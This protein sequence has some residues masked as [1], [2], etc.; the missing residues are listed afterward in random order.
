MEES[1][2]QFTLGVIGGGTMAQAIVQGAVSSHFLS[3][4]DIVVS[5][6]NSERR[7][8]FSNLGVTVT[9]DNSALARSCRYLLLAVK[10]QDHKTVA[11]EIRGSNPPVLVSIMA[12]VSK[13]TL[14][15]AF[16]AQ[17]IARVMPNLPC[18]IQKGMAGIDASELRADEADFVFGLFSVIGKTLSVKEEQ[19]NAVT[20]ISGSGPAY[21]YLFLKALTEAGKA[22]GLKE[23]QASELA[24]QTVKGGVFMAEQTTQTLDELIAA[25]SSKGGTTLAALESFQRDDFT[26]AVLRAVTACVNRAEELSE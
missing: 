12:G 23:A 11:N 10:P 24:I 15:R 18:R 5:D 19:L 21:V 20:G 6:P 17:T 1:Q 3:A 13:N 2:K 9:D 14:H 7:N 25:V 4:D 26:G 8:Y 16:H 22:H